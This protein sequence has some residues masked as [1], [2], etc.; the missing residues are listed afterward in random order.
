M[1]VHHHRINI[2][3]CIYTVCTVRIPI[4]YNFEGEFGS[5]DTTED[6]EAEMVKQKLQSQ[7]VSPVCLIF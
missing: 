7:A 2:P 4:A 6:R 3:D 1:Y 5:V